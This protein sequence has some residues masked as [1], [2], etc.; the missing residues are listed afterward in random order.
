MSKA[1]TVVSG[2]TFTV[3]E[4]MGDTGRLTVREVMTGETFELVE[5]SDELVREHV[6]A[7]GPGSTVRLVLGSAGEPEDPT[8]AV[9][10]MPPSAVPQPCGAD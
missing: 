5:F 4:P 1:K 7:L 6:K 8:R 10:Q 3:V 9:M 2:R